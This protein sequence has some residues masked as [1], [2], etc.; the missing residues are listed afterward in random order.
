MFVWIIFLLEFRINMKDKC[1]SVFLSLRCKHRWPNLTKYFCATEKIKAQ[2]ISKLFEIYGQSEAVGIWTSGWLV[3]KRNRCVRRQCSINKSPGW[4]VVGIVFMLLLYFH[5]I[6]EAHCYT[7]D[8]ECKAWS[9]MSMSKEDDDYD[10][11][12]VSAHQFNHAF[13]TFCKCQIISLI[14]IPDYSIY[15]KT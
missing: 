5:H 1:L 2:C 13:A 4:G 8:T 12:T 11:T 9:L 14:I 6:T 10:K 7:Q 15:I 3:E